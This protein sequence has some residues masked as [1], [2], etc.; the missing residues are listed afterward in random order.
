MNVKNLIEGVK[1]REPD[2][3]RQL[4]ILLYENLFKV[5]LAYCV[6]KEEAT[7]VF[8]YSVADIFK[9]LIDVEDEQSLLKWAYKI[10]KNDCIDHVRK[11]AM[12]KKKLLYVEADC[13]E[14]YASND[15][16]SNL[17]MDEILKCINQ[18]ND[19]YRLCFVMYELDGMTHKEI[20]NK[21]NIKVNTS[22]W[23]LAEAKK[24]L[25]EMVLK[26]GITY[27]PK[28]KLTL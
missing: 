12:Y 13:L 4:Y 22:K 15:A 14:S 5:P 21:L 24:K 26:K 8:N 6:D 19:T 9:N 11:K 27:Y 1:K 2:K 23:Y 10:L 25:R 18:L 7:G 3:E 17:N 28:L 20:A 16:I